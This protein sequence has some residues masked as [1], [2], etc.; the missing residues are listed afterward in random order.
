[1]LMKK[2]DE[3]ERLALRDSAK[4]FAQRA[5]ESLQ[6]ALD[7][8][9][10]ELAAFVC[11]LLNETEESA[12]YQQLREDIRGGVLP[13]QAL[14]NRLSGLFGSFIF[15]RR[16]ACVLYAADNVEKWA[17][18]AEQAGGRSFRSAN[19][20][21]LFNRVR[22]MLTWFISQD[23]VD[24][25]P[26]DILRGDVSEE[27]RAFIIRRRVILPPCE[28][29]CEIDHGN[30]AFIAELRRVLL[31]ESEVD[32]DAYI[33]RGVLQSSHAGLHQLLGKLLL[34]AR[35]QEGLR[36]AICVNA[37][38]GTVAGFLE[39]LRVI[40]ENDLVRFS[41]VKLALGVWTG[42]IANLYDARAHDLERISA[43]TLDLLWEALTDA[44]ARE[45][46]LRSE[47]S[48]KI[49]L[50]LWAC[51]VYEADDAAARIL[52]LAEEGSQHQILTACYALR[53]FCHK[54]LRHQAASAILARHRQQDILAACMESF[55]P[56]ASLDISRTARHA[57]KSSRKRRPSCQLRAYF[58]DRAEAER[59]Y[60][61]LLEIHAGIKGK[62]LKIAP[63]IF[64]WYAV[65]LSRCDTALRLC[66]LASAL[67]DDARIDQV[68]D[69]L[70]DL[71]YERKSV[72]ALL[73]PYPRT[74]KQKRV[75]VERLCDKQEDAREQAFALAKQ[76]EFSDEHYLLMEEMLRYKN[77]E[78]RRN[79]ISLLRKRDDE[80]LLATVT[81]LLSDKKEERRTAGLDLILQLAEDK[82]RQALYA[83]C[84]ALTESCE[85]ST[86]REKI[87]AG[88]IVPTE[89]TR[90]AE[91]EPLY[92]AGDSYQPVP[93]AALLTRAGEVYRKYLYHQ[94]GPKHDFELLNE[95]LLALMAAHADDEY[96]DSWGDVRTLS[97]G[98]LHR[99]WNED[100]SWHLPLSELW[101]AFYSQEAGSP[102]LVL[103]AF[104]SVLSEGDVD[105]CATKCSRFVSRHIGAEFAR[106]LMVPQL[107]NVVH[108]YQ[109]LL[110]RHA[111]REE[112][113]LLAVHLAHALSK[114]KSLRVDYSYR[115]WDGSRRKG[116][117]SV[118]SYQPFEL[119][120][121]PLERQSHAEV[122]KLFPICYALEQ[123]E[124]ARCS[125]TL[126]NSRDV[127]SSVILSGYGRLE[128]SDYVGAAFQGII[129]ERFMYRSLLEH[130]SN[131]ERDDVDGLHF[132][133]SAAGSGREAEELDKTP[134]LLAF[135]RAA[136]EKVLALVLHEELRR[137][138]SP[139]RF[140]RQSF[141][142]ARIE[143]AAYYVRILAALGREPL[144]RNRRQTYCHQS[145]PA[146]RE[147]L[148]HLLEVCVPGRDDT[149]E[150]LAALL[151]ETDIGEERLVEAAMY[152]PEWLD[153]T[154]QY[155]GW[156]G[157][158]SACYYFMAHTSESVDE[159]R[160]AIMARYTPL[161][162]EE[163]CHGA[164]DVNW[165]RQAHAALGE[166]RFNLIYK[167]AKY[168]ADGARHTRA[169]KYA[170]A[171][172]G[173]L[174]AAE[175][176]LAIEQKRN[177]D[178]LMAWALI[179]MEHEE[180]PLERYLYLQQF[181]RESKKFGAQRMASEKLAVEMALRNLAGTVGCADVMRLCLRMETRL[182]ES[183]RALMEEKV[184]GEHALRLV[185]GADGRA[186]IH[187]AKG[188]RALK[189]IPAKLKKEAHV[190]LLTETKK[191][192]NEQHAR[193][194]RMLEQAMEDS[195]LYSFGELE[196]LRQNPVVA[197][198][199]EHIV[200]ICGQSAGFL[201]E[202]GLQGVDGRLTLLAEADSLRVAH[203]FDLYRAGCWAAFQQDLFAR[204]IVQPFR[205]VFRELYVKTPEELTMRSSLRYAGHQVQVKKMLACLKQRRWVADVENGLQ[206][207][208]YGENI[209]ARIYARADWFTPSEIEAPMLEWV[210]FYH[211]QTEEQLELCRVPDILFS[212]VM[213]DVDM[214]VSVAHA[215]GVDPESS[216]ST[217]EMRAAL[218]RFTLPLFKLGNVEIKGSHVHICGSR[219]DYTLHLGSGVVHQKGGTMLSILPVHSQHRGRL[220]LPFADDDPK[221]AEIIS[222][223]L[224]LAEDD[225]LHD[226]TIL[227]QL[228]R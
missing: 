211:R 174:S 213:R 215:G 141:R 222:K 175:T 223:V 17:H 148:S 140:S 43:R 46:Y 25:S 188:G 20:E 224:L 220:F 95:K 34:A 202:G 1:M 164:F 82:D 212:E 137:G 81:R 16:R 181:L 190:L 124:G 206:K 147:C 154:E 199:L 112:L 129:S 106:R 149:P 101:E 37:D 120:L 48:M 76:L 176:R 185:I 157:F 204:G 153:I 119:L 134:G 121:H 221:T 13:S 135:A 142:I 92:D 109:Y 180:E 209:V 139:T 136:G 105:E 57:R 38:Q 132:L 23:W 91:P 5:E 86:T 146:R 45:A 196:A 30:E 161:S 26:L 11:D 117:S 179:P 133:S 58:A 75:L 41:S 50:G 14:E 198:L 59:F 94:R 138:D 189:S 178:L 77:A 98:E 96:T 207:V 84:R 90:N 61:I 24:R 187:C 219:A 103:R 4:R 93:D 197:P 193:T 200:F 28:I 145:Q 144:S 88:R 73:L 114:E 69:F 52:R 183:T 83:Q 27:E 186:D 10:D 228:N 21:L 130:L 191:T 165:F 108:I 156:P 170:D 131:D 160:E 68:L 201:S 173:K 64:P 80:T 65:T 123:T 167:A 40:R 67:D 177:K 36:Q 3:S 85:V 192:L 104:L 102:V 205:Q 79:L 32:V 9:D 168:S 53:H 150:A 54:R 166:K 15:S 18:E 218:L 203:P 44:D 29:A 128:A 127:G 63:C 99:F 31:T 7:A 35:Q 226:P 171:A 169:R 163:L 125:Q 60:D 19:R 51:G 2:Y 56:G 172:S 182:M 66:W 162:R 151:K 110:Y 217:M 158:K 118:L 155:L 195:A 210:E 184:L 143:G 115:H 47:D 62:S 42:L 107:E 111:D 227:R 22:D 97:G 214:A 113:Q 74:E 55:M 12:L 72:I 100:G 78:A 39:V 152:S 6:E 216:H 49:H 159:R 71:D 126:L 122:V 8:A 208:C 194:R 225:K 89:E 70:G 33:I 87:L 116:A